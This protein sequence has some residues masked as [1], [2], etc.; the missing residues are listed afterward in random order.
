LA[1]RRGREMREGAR[2]IEERIVGEQRDERKR[3]R[4]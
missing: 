2:E 1:S 4:Q 3:E